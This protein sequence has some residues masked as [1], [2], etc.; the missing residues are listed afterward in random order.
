MDN[1]LLG[2]FLFSAYF[3]FASC[4]LFDKSEFSEQLDNK[5]IATNNFYQEVKDLMKVESEYFE[6]IIENKELNNEKIDLVKIISEY[7]KIIE[8]DTLKC[9]ELRKIATKLNIKIQHQG[10]VKN[11]QMLVSDI[12]E[13]LN[14][15]DSIFARSQEVIKS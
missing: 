11:K 9:T 15:N 1:L 12:Q 6:E 14:K 4:L 3:S 5:E 8:L 10:K 13:Q 7:D 2:L